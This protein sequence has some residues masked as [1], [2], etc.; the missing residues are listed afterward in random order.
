VRSAS[1]FLNLMLAG[2]FLLLAGQWF[3][4]GSTAWA[5]FA[6]L[7]VAM[8]LVL[9]AMKFREAKVPPPFP[10]PGPGSVT[11]EVRVTGADR[12]AAIKAL[13]EAVPGL[14]L[15]EGRDVVDA[16]MSG[17]TAVL[18]RAATPEQAADIRR[19]LEASG[20]GISVV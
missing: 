6:A 15:A 12:I 18:T 10:E 9:A 19:S 2:V 1:A 7:A 16:A 3:Q 5:A 20:A 17:G 13:R 8:N 4:E 14:G 11:V